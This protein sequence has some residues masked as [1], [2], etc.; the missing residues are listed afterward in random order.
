[1]QMAESRHNKFRLSIATAK[2]QCP[3]RAAELTLQ[4]I[5]SSDAGAHV[6]MLHVFSM[7]SDLRHALLLLVSSRSSLVQGPEQRDQQRIYRLGHNLIFNQR[8][9]NCHQDHGAGLGAPPTAGQLSSTARCD[10]RV[11]PMEGH[12]KSFSSPS[13]YPR[14]TRH[15]TLPKPFHNEQLCF[16][17]ERVRLRSRVD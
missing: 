14:P 17:S 2:L 13:S 8:E 11:G 15:L 12:A 4:V 16:T 3:G 9:R 1:M 7:Y 10:R 5:S 6:M